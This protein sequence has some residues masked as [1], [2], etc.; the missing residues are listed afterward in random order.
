MKDE[1]ETKYLVR[2][3]APNRAERRAHERRL[4]KEGKRIM[5]QAARIAR[6]KE[7]CNG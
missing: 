6:L 5:V 1:R 7:E 4:K 2:H 3:A